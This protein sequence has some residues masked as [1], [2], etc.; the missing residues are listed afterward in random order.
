MMLTTADLQ[1][2][3]KRRL[4]R[5]IYDFIEGGPGAERALD[6]NIEAFRDIALIPRVLTECNKRDL[7][8]EFLGKRYAAPFGVSPMGIGNAAWPGTDLALARAMG[9]AKLP[10]SLST[11][12]STSVEEMAKAANGYLW[13]QLY[14]NMTREIAA[15]L[16]DRAAAS[17]VDV[18][19]FTV[20]ANVPSRRLR[21]LRHQLAMPLKFRPG[22]IAQFAMAPQWSI[23]TALAGPPGMGNLKKYLAGSGNDLKEMLAAMATSRLI[24]DDLSWLRDRWRGKLVVKGVMGAADAKHCQALGADAVMVSNHGGRQ[25]SSA[26][27]SIEALPAV[28]AA[29]GPDYPLLLDS[30]VRTGEDILKALTLGANF[31]TMGRPFL[32]AS[33]AVGPERGGRKVVEIV[34]AEIDNAL[35]N[36]G[37]NSLA[38]LGPD[39]L[40]K[41]LPRN[42]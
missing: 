9:E 34:R 24:W 17:G 10:Y 15:D 42:Y 33:A 41:P 22:L 35:G 20:D 31:V 40:H 32:F 18:L 28:R 7:S 3:A 5:L 11:A 36:L 29:V 13:F 21:D 6:R 26:V 27:S 30:G 23:A 8:V 14:I 16:C 2:G 19:I 38:E 37:C 25:L 12:G 1:R 4:P 39:L